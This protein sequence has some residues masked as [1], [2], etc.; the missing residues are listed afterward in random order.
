MLN[1]TDPRTDARANRERV[2]AAAH[3]LFSDR[4]IGAEIRDI[5]DRAGVA[6]GTIYRNYPT[7]G[8]LV[9]AVLAGV[10]A[11][12]DARAEAAEGLA[13][14]VEALFVMLEGTIEMSQHYGWLG[15]AVIRGQFQ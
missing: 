11:E 4:G 1:R 12:A 6:V 14:P 3:E 10:I 8:D 13:D 5:A 7:K 9:A 15:E 2:I